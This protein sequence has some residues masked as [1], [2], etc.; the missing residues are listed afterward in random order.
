M[1]AGVPFDRRDGRFPTLQRLGSP[2]LPA[3][4][5]RVK[6]MSVRAAPL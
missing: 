1:T 3:G 2:F 5:L 4:D 6:L